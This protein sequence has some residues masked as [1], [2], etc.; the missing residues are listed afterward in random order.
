MLLR[1]SPSER[2]AP[3]LGW[4]GVWPALLGRA[5]QQKLPAATRMPIPPTSTRPLLFTL[6]PHHVARGR[7]GVL[8]AGLQVTR[9]GSDLR[10]KPAS[11]RGPIPSGE[12]PL[13]LPARLQ[14]KA[15][16]A[17]KVCC[18]WETPPLWPLRSRLRS[19]DPETGLRA[20]ASEP[21]ACPPDLQCQ[22]NKARL[23]Q[24]A[25]QPTASL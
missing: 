14:G 8:D 20:D 17:G 4:C 5:G 24:T 25:A 15:A 10:G 13:P 12:V 3:E 7:L 22:Y 11:R 9:Q 1:L 23:F 21:Q 18:R 2:N 16:Y 6:N 19:P